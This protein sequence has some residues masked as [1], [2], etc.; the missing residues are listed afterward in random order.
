MNANHSKLQ[1]VVDVD[2]S[3][4]LLISV[5]LHALGLISTVSELVCAGG[6][7]S[8][9]HPSGGSYGKGNDMNI[10]KLLFDVDTFEGFGNYFGLLTLKLREALALISESFDL[11]KVIDLYM[12]TGF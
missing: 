2:V 10:A 4:S 1:I 8:L 12:R 9:M 6:R 5:D 7:A 11:G 3:K